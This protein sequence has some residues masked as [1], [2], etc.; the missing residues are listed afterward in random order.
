MRDKLL[1]L[2]KE[3]SF[4][5]RRVVLS[6]G[7]E[8]DFYV[9]VKQTALH[10]QGAYLIG[11]L[12][13]GLLKKGERVEAI[14]GMTMGAD[15]LAV[16]VSLLSYLAQQGKK[17]PLPAFFVRKE[18]KKHGTEQWLEGTK[19]LKS[20]TAVAI[21]EDVVTSGAQALSA[22]ERVE[23]GGFVVK[24]VIAVVDREEGGREEIERKGYV[25]ES[26]FRRSDFF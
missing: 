1:S 23:K 15:P 2:L 8:S 4:E 25:F 22:I 18:P 24:R 21:L 10:P 19:N 14:G 5:K 26:L 20:G 7:K 16:S 3:K 9:D 12:I 11:K 6:S 17:M 13:L